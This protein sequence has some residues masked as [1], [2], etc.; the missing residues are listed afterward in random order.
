MVLIIGGAYQGKRLYAEELYPNVAWL[1]GRTCKEEDIFRCQGIH[2]FHSYIQRM[3]RE[4]KDLENFAGKLMTENPGLILVSDE[5]GCGIVPVDP[6]D[7][8]YREM[9]GRVCTQLAACAEE[10]YRVVCGIGMRIKG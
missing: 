5:I 1:D 2:H 7:R 10:V 9:T 3:M 6:F 8:Q 4:G